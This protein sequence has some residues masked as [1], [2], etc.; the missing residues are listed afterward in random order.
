MRE[1]LATIVAAERLLAGMDANM[2]L[3]V[4]LEFECL[5]AVL[6][7]EFAQQRRFVVADHVALQAVHVGERF[8]A[9]LAALNRFGN[10]QKV[11]KKI[12]D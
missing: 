1:A 11:W 5:V 4:M 2:L 10:E 9:Q 7:F 6:A 3:E 8:L 12:V